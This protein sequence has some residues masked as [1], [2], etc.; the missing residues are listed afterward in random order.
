[1]RLG[2]PY[3]LILRLNLLKFWI[4]RGTIY[5]GAPPPRG[6]VIPCPEGR[7]EMLCSGW[8]TAS[9]RS[10][11]YAYYEINAWILPR[12][13]KAV[14]SNKESISFLISNFKWFYVN[15]FGNIQF[16]LTFKLNYF[17]NLP[18][19]LITIRPTVF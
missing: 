19:E 11:K 4:W 18:Q 3:T 15:S 5:T 9:L 17:K 12:N 1:M 2:R 8:N 14:K 16:Y 6:V 10:D 13:Q 7:A